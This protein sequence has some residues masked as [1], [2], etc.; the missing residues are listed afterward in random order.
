MLSGR[1]DPPNKDFNIVYFCF[2][3]QSMKIFD[4]FHLKSILICIAELGGRQIDTVSPCNPIPFGVCVSICWTSVALINMHASSSHPC[5]ITQ[6][7]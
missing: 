5:D 7:H 2:A 3:F 4:D 1:S 6:V